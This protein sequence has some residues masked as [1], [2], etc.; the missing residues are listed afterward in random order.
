[1]SDLEKDA[2][3]YRWLK[4]QGSLDLRTCYRSKWTRLE[5]GETYYP[6][7][8]LAVNGT[9]FSGVE[10]LDDLIDQAI[11]IYPLA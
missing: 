11:E 1:M 2:S 4:A 5:T 8:A 3:R 6:S 10:H 9:G 7:H